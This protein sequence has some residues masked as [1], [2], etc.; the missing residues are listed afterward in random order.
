MPPLRSYGGIQLDKR[1][2]PVSGSALVSSSVQVRKDQDFNVIRDVYGKEA[3]DEF[4]RKLVETQNIELKY[5][6]RY[7]K[8]LVN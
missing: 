5:D 3:D 2:Q 1:I 4:L 6:D 8:L 7:L